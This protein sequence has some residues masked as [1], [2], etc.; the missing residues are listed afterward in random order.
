V[1]LAGYSDAGDYW[2]VKN[3]W[4]SSWNGDGYFKVGYGECFIENE[5]YYAE[6]PTE[7]TPS[8]TPTP[9]RTRTP[10]NTPATG[11]PT[12]TRTPTPTGTQTPGQCRF[13]DS[14]R[15]TALSITGNQFVFTG[16]GGFEVQ[17]T[18]TRSGNRVSIS[19]RVG[20]VTVFGSG[21][22]PSGPGRFSAIRLGFPPVIL[23]LID[24]SAT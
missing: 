5:V 4:G 9:T 13:E 15:G 8:P 24:T 22:C 3:S 17:G 19:S 16:P 6:A 21:T 11:S 1:V 7:V 12:P 14:A 18:A 20:N 23:R 2:I 10:T